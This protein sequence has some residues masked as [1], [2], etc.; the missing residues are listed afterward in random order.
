MMNDPIRR[1]KSQ[2]WKPL[3]GVAFATVIIVSLLDVLLIFLINNV[4]TIQ[5]SI[6]FLL[7]SPL[8]ILIPLAVAA[9]VGALGVSI[10]D[11]YRSKIF[12]TAGSLWALVLCLMIALGINALIPFPS[13]LLQLSYPTL[14]GV[15]IGVFWRGRHYWR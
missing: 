12:L 14:I 9:G 1:F 4:A 3:F 13:F 5:D 6:R 10:C 8:G 15:M 11:Y 2:P 7:S